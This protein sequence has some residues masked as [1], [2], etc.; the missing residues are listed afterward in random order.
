MRYVKIEKA[1]YQ[2]RVIVANHAG[3]FSL[4]I[5]PSQPAEVNKTL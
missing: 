1:D 5:S 3:F 2:N 4:K